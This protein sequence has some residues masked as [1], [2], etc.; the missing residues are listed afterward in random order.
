M[1]VTRFPDDWLWMDAIE[2]QRDGGCLRVRST[3][4]KGLCI[5][6]ISW[7]V[8]RHTWMS[9]MLSPLA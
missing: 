3:W 4:P 9:G 2:M 8:C 6:E 5:R 7:N 1:Q